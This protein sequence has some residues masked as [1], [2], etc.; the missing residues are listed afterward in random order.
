MNSNKRTMPRHVKSGTVNA[1]RNAADK[2]LAAEFAARRIELEA[3]L[4]AIFAASKA[5][6]LLT[7]EQIAAK[8]E[9]YADHD[10]FARNGIER[11]IQ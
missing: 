8:L 4:D 6:L 10:D 11:S 5:K 3:K 7:D 2:R 9:D 1:R